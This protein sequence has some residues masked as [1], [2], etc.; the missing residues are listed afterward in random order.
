MTNINLLL[1]PILKQNE[2]V[3]RMAEKRVD[4]LLINVNKMHVLTKKST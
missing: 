1:P 3:K 2:N 4:A